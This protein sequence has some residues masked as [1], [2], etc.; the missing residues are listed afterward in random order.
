MQHVAVSNLY[1][2]GSLIGFASGL[3]MTL[4]LLRLVI[5]AWHLPG[6]RGSHMLLVL[7]ALA[8]NIG[9]GLRMAV[10]AMS[11]V[12]SETG[13]IGSAIQFT[14]AAVWPVALLGLWR[15]FAANRW[16]QR[17]ARLLFA[18]AILDAGVIATA[19]WLAALA[20]I[21]IVSP[22]LVKQLTSFNGSLLAFGAV[23]SLVRRPSSRTIWFS[24]VATV[25]GVVTTTVGI[26]LVNALELRPN[27][28]ATV[29]VV[30]EQSTLLI[31]LGAFFLFA[32]FRFADVFIR[33]SLRIV[34]VAVV[35]TTL[36]VVSR[37]DSLLRWADLTAWPE[38][39]RLFTLFL[40]ASALLS[41]FMIVER[42]LDRF[43]NHV[44]MAIP[45][46]RGALQDWRQRLPDLQSEQEVFDSAQTTIRDVLQIQ[47][48]QSITTARLAN[49]TL[50]AQLLEGHVVEL[51]SEPPSTNANGLPTVEV[52]VPVRTGDSV[53]AAFAISRGRNC[54][55][56]LTH[57]VDY[58]RAVALYSGMRI[59]GLRRERERLERH[60]RDS[61]LQKQL[62]EAEL[63]ALRAQINPH[64][65]FNA[66]NTVADLIVT[67][68]RA[69]ETVTLQLAKIFRHVLAVSGR[70]MT[71]IAEELDFLRAYMQIEE[72]R[73]AGRLQVEIEMQPTLARC[74]IPSLILQP[75][76]ENA[77]KHGLAPKLGA[78]H[79]W[80]SAR[81][82]NDRVA[83]QVVDD[84]VGAARQTTRSSHGVGL[85][86]IAKRLALAYNGHASLHL[87]PRPAG[88][89][90]VTI[91][92]PWCGRAA[93]PP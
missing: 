65:L 58:L 17:A 89:T 42:N 49:P 22:M 41:A 79:L 13:T 20:D 51:D 11:G 7:C 4:L 84:G 27:V 39:M 66:L 59:D 73:F 19:L 40:L 74:P 3:A 8:W 68:P 87:A 75:I 18:V 93:G 72:A 25:I 48:V 63:R 31:L 29:V 71:S 12:D 37:S 85:A 28:E 92:L 10:S 81:A 69:A 5:R 43:V 6:D 32:K 62:A 52:L 78:G 23:A 70:S 45:D 86:N 24:L 33:Q 91:S 88:G 38:S 50:S 36:V 26:T 34:A 61:L 16:Q 64:F 55:G 76:V 1:L 2:A 82:E 56:F 90:C 83:L 77:L 54:G 14:G 57:E 53:D 67:N 80:V 35:A 15:S 60:H 9:G 47:N 46:Y 21:R 30:S 44:V